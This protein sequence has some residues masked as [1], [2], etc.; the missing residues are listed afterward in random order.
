MG[1]LDTFRAWRV[2][3]AVATLR[4]YGYNGAQPSRLDNWTPVN[5]TINHL[6]G[7]ASP[8]LRARVRDLV[9]NF[10]LFTRGV[11]GYTAFVVGRGARFQSLA[12]LPDGSPNLTARRKIEQRFRA[13]MESDACVN[14]KMH[15]YELQ[16]LLCRQMMECGEGLFQEVCRKQYRI[17]PFSL[18]PIE[19]DRLTD[20]GARVDDRESQGVFAGIEY[21][22]ET[23]EPTYYNIADDGY[24]VQTHRVPAARIFHVFQTLRCGQLRGVTPFAPAIIVARAMADYTQ[25]ELDSA[26][27]AAKYL[28][29]ITTDN[30]EGFQAARGLIGKKGP[31]TQ[32]PIEN[33]ENAIIEYLRPNEK[34]EFANTPNRPGDS[35]DRFSRFATRMV[36]I[37]VDV[38]YEIMSGDYTNINYSTSKASRGDAGMLLAPHKFLLEQRFSA[39][40]F[41]RWLDYEALTQDYLPNYWQDPELYRRSMWIP[42]G[43]PSVDPQRDGRADIDAI[44]ACL[45]SPQEAILGRGA[46]PEE[47]LA[48][49]AEWNSMVQLYNVQVGQPSTAMAHNPAALDDQPTDT[50]GDEDATATL[51]PAAT[52]APVVPAEPVNPVVENTA[53]DTTVSDVTFNGAQVT[54][55]LEVIN[56]VA[57]GELPRASGIEMLKVAFSLT[58]TQAENMMGEVGKSFVPASAQNTEA[59]NV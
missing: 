3:K 56:K 26:K 31:A 1:V 50:L 52:P 59:S 51:E 39:P 23:G 4:H 15:F 18:L 7:H 22:R 9:R 44:V 35:F 24:T 20:L 6:I 13:W 55:M 32:P 40:I 41:R 19:P 33:L 12:M 21:L 53:S 45:K 47:V 48:Q 27:M 14:G 5:D 34:I 29:M 16:Q 58:E 28:A 38:P 57:L 30:A 8:R 37:C 43:M 17:N 36:S 2:K 42:A 11:N 46:D 49:T 54:S 10:P 25:S